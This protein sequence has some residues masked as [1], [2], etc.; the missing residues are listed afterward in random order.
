MDALTAAG[1]AAAAFLTAATAL[2]VFFNAVTTITVD[3]YGLTVTQQSGLGPIK[4]SVKKDYD[5]LWA[6]VNEVYD[7]EKRRLTKHGIRR[8][9]ARRASAP[10]TPQS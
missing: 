5:L 10:S 3:R 7:V 8:S 4:G 9:S 1:V 6:S 2:Y